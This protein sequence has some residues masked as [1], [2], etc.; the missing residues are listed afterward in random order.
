[1][2][3]VVLLEDMILWIWRIITIENPCDFPDF[4]DLWIVMELHYLGSN[5]Y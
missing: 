4:K 2:S 5:N 3:K 1:M